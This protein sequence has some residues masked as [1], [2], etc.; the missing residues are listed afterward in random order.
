MKYCAQSNLLRTAEAMAAGTGL[1][2]KLLSVRVPFTVSSRL[3]VEHF[4]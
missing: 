3:L 1:E 2:A 4:S